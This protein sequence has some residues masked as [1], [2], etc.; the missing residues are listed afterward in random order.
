MR[1]IK[2]SELSA[3]RR[4][5]RHQRAHAMAARTCII[6]SVVFALAMGISRLSH[7]MSL[8]KPHSPAVD[9]TPEAGSGDRLESRP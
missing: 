2:Q 3:P 6:M 7:M 5:D 8:P 9:T 1:P 4:A